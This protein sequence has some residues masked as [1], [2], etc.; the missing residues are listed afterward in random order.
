LRAIWFVTAISVSLINPHNF[1]RFYGDV[2]QVCLS[3]GSYFTDTLCGPRGATDL[4]FNV[5]K[6][7]YAAGYAEFDVDI[8]QAYAGLFA[9]R[10]QQMGGAAGGEDASMAHQAA[11]AWFLRDPALPD[12]EQAAQFTYFACRIWR[13]SDAQQ[14]LSDSAGNF[15]E[16]A[17]G[18]LAQISTSWAYET[19][20][21]AKQR[22][23]LSGTTLEPVTPPGCCLALTEYAF[24]FAGRLFARHPLVRPRGG[25]VL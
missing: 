24:V 5:W 19:C 11:E 23:F 9:K 3:N 22:V 8:V 18:S 6:Q 4:R 21:R 13:N 25:D 17:S 1:N 7:R 16:F 2:T 12:T 10:S 15:D 20:K 14:G